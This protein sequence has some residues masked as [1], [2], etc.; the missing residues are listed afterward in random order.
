MQTVFPDYYKDFKCINKQCRHNCCI[1]W[2]IDIDSKTA[3]FYR[4]H[5][6]ILK[7]KF[8]SCINWNKEPYFI[9]SANGRCP[10]LNDDNLC[11]I[12]IN[13]SEEALCTICSEHPRFTNQLPNRNEIGLGLCCEAAGNLILGKK[14]P[15]KLIINGE[16]DNYDDIIK[17]RNKLILILQNREKSIPSRIDDMLNTCNCNMPQKSFD[18]YIDFLLSLE[19]LDNKWDE[20]LLFLKNNISNANFK[21]FDLHMKNRQTEY[22]QLLVYFIYRH[23]ANAPELIY[24]AE[25][26]L[27]AAFAYKIIYSIGAVIFAKNKEFSFDSQVEIARM[28]SSEIEYS[29]ENLYLIFDFLTNS[30]EVI[31]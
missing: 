22:E 1:G 26:A 4:N 20:I 31:L 21:A 16:T 18:K 7:D 11:E 9:L 6:G 3:S 2:E 30:S 13:Y 8:R 14:E 24:T 17:L 15:V 19:R 10:F 28:F 5:E 25:R 12:I 29:D 23:F 27:F